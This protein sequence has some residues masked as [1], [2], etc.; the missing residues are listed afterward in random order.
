M[1][2]LLLSFVAALIAVQMPQSVSAQPQATVPLSYV[3]ID[4]DQLVDAAFSAPY[5][6]LLLAEF[7]SALAGSAD[8]ACLQ[9]KGIETSSL[10]DRARAITVRQG[11]QFIRRFVA[12]VDR[13]ALKAAFAARIGADAEAELAKL[14]DHPD[15]RPFIVLDTVG[16]DAAVANSIIEMLDRNLLVLK[17]KLARRF[18]P[19]ATGNQKLIEADPSDEIN[20]KL[21][22]LVAT[23]KSAALARYLEL[24]DAAQEALDQSINTKT[25]L[26]VRNVDLMP[27]LENDMADVC[28]GRQQ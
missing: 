28:I 13:P 8:E 5:G 9:G 19:L 17:V 21:D 26:G 27:G 12:M 11:A 6:R 15:V 23:N 7:A 25:L 18:H 16:R 10:P 14:R 22:E 20:D 24:T 2:L 3:D 4:P 1:R